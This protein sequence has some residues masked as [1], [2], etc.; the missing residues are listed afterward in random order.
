M[1]KEKILVQMLELTEM[2]EYEK[3]EKEKK[4]LM[5]K[6]KR[7]DKKLKETQNETINS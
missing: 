1:E 4:K 6:F 7:L 3:D 5:A 2:Y